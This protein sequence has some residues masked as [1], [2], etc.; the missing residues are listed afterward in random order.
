LQHLLHTED[1]IRLA[2]ASLLLLA[3]AGSAGAST[4][5]SG[6]HGTVMRGPTQPVCMVGEPCEEPAPGVV[7]HIA[8]AATGTAVT[9]VRTG[10]GGT[11]RVRLAPGVYTIRTSGR[12]LGTI[13]KPVTV[14]VVRGRFTRRNLS[15]DTG[16]R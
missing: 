16:I 7:L 15:I 5:A 3:L 14:R 4:P 9:H 1:V 8:R 6:I 13:L 12:T 11:Y 2:A 10:A